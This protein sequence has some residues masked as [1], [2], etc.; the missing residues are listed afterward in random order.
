MNGCVGIESC[1]KK[2]ISKI[3]K[4][5]YLVVVCCCSYFKTRRR[6][7]PGYQFESCVCVD[8][9]RS[10]YYFHKRRFKEGKKPHTTNCGGI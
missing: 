5:V 4:E 7:I 9:E 10:R 2:A 8:E 1:E 3:L 6:A